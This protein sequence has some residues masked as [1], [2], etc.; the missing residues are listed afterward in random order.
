MELK[1][2]NNILQIQIL[3]QRVHAKL[4]D[5]IAKAKAEMTKAHLNVSDR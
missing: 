3:L 2:A 5:E 1:L 4:V